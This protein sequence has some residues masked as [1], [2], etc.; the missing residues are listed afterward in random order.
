MVKELKVK[1]IE[2][3]TVIDHIP[4]GMAFR[5]IDIIAAGRDLKKPMSIVMNVESSG[6]VKK[7]IVKME[8][9]EL[10][11][12]EV[13]KIAL[14]APDATINIIRGFEVVEKMTVKP[15]K[16]VTG[17]VKCSNPNCISNQKEPVVPEFDVSST[18]PLKL[19][20]IYCERDLLDIMRNLV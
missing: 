10:R 9:L 19:R 18:S 16:R 5:V 15:P 11:K 7:D 2:N 1:P 20:C 12:R 14:I 8:D 13:D 3:G 6:I 4:A 17:I